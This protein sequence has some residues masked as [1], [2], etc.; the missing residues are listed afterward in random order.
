MSSR[1]PPPLLP[2]LAILL[3]VTGCV[4]DG[5]EPA[6]AG[7]VSVP[8]I[9]PAVDRL[10]SAA[11]VVIDPSGEPVAELTVRVAHTR[12]QRRRGLME[13]EELPPGSG[14]LFVYG[15]DGRRSFWMKD[16]PIPLD[17]AW[18]TSG[19]EVVAITTM[20]PCAGDP[21]P[22]YAPDADHRHVLEVAAGTFADLGVEPGWELE[23]PED[24]PSER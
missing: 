7:Q 20:Q 14:M 15:T 16:T 8:P 6:D 10:P 18:V 2:L 22:S 23:L 13:V 21:C 17:I 12:E 4:S 3:A 24:L 9:H 5:T 1:P 19:G 11:L